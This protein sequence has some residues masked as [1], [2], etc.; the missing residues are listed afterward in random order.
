MTKTQLSD[1]DF[2]KLV[3]Q[4]NLKLTDEEKSKVHAQLYEAL[5]SVKIMSELDT[6]KV[7]QLSSASGLTNV[8]REDE[9]KP[10]FPQDL[11]LQNARQTHSG[12]FMVPSIFESQD[13]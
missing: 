3:K 1:K 8:L 5:N 6:S 12:Y 10:S 2:A 9:V 7:S 13:N 4:A 11:A